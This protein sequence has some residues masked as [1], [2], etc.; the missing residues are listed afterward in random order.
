[1]HFFLI[2]TSIWAAIQESCAVGIEAGIN[3][4]DHLITAYRA[5]GYTYTRGVP[6]KEIMAELTGEMNNLV[7]GSHLP[8]CWL[9][10]S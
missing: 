3:L 8:W 6:V 2:P 1:M 5:H 7:V 4:S 9:C 10:H